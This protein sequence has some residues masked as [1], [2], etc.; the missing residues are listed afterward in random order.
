MKR[1]FIFFILILA[2]STPKISLAEEIGVYK[3]A[4]N[5]LKVLTE[6]NETPDKGIPQDLLSNCAGI[7]IFP[8]VLKAGFIIGANYGKG[9]LIARDP[10]TNKWKGPTFLT[11]GGGS[12]GWQIGV[13]AT[14]FVLV[15]MNENG[16]K[17]FLNNNLTLGAGLSIAAG[18]V[19][20]K[21][22][23]ATD[24]TLKAEVY[25]YS[26]SKGFFA[27]IS[28]QGTYIYNDYDS[29]QAFYMHPYLPSEILFGNIKNVPE[30]A[31][32]LLDYMNKHY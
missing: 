7:A 26:R 12:L 16:V 30:E 15:I 17:A 6:L 28:L 25:S 24:A 8:R 5:A 21:L 29:N 2:I 3:R 13:E 9:I 23:A 1:L 32:A 22:E 20:R 31:Q 4:T 11:I 18:P 14:D 19:G 27:G 10:K